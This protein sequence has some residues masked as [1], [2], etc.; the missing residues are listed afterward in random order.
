MSHFA[1]FWESPEEG[2]ATLAL[3]FLL[4]IVA[5][6]PLVLIAL[7]VVGAG[8]RLSTPLAVAL[9]AAI[10]VA[11]LS[12]IHLAAPAARLLE[13]LLFDRQA[14]S[15]RWRALGLRLRAFA[16]SLDDARRAGVL[17]PAFALSIVV[18]LCKYGG[19]FFLVLSLLMPLGYSIAELGVFRV[20]LGGVAAEIA[21]AL[22]IHGLAGFGTYEAAWTLTL[23]ELGY[24]RE[25][26]VISG[27][28]AH[29]TTQMLEYLL[30]GVAFLWLMRSRQRAASDPTGLDGR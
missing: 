24:P 18:R 14:G 27:L 11:G 19:A 12:A 28:V 23:E 22:P 13:R 17:L 10:A 29:A 8:G 25:H 4:D 3:A 9:S 15:H 20:F 2:I 26:A 1:R 6:S 5:L 16:T 7:L 30:G 21:A